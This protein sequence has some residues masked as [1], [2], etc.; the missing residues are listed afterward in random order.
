M[1]KPIFFLFLL[2]IL[3]SFFPKQTS[4]QTQEEKIFKNIFQQ[5]LVI[6]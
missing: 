5:L 2:V 4:A 6:K 1:K 3:T